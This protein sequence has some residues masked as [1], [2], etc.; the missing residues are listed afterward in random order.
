MFTSDS[1][2]RTTIA[3]VASVAATAKVTVTY[4]EP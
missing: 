2:I 4:H 1:N 3:A